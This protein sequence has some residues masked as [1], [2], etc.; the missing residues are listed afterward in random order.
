M[1]RSYIQ[2]AL[3]KGKASSVSAKAR[4]VDDP[5]FAHA[6]VETSKLEADLII[7]GRPRETPRRKKAD[8]VVPL[9]N[10]LQLSMHCTSPGVEPFHS[11]LYLVR[12]VIGTHAKLC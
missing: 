8:L 5:Q 6:D 2:R 11:R 4:R 7:T 9:S 12:G 1:K 3:D 10:R